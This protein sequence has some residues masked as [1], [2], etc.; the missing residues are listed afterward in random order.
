VGSTFRS[1]R[2]L[3]LI[4]AGLVG[5]AAAGLAVG[6]A[7]GYFQV[8]PRVPAYELRRD[9][10][11][12]GL[13]PG[14]EAVFAFRFR[15]GLPRCWAQVDRPSG[16]ETLSLD[17]KPAAVQ[18][19]APRTPPDEVEGLVAL[20]GPAGQGDTYTLHLV[21]TKL[22]FP[23]GRRPLGAAFTATYWTGPKPAA[24]KPPEPGG[25]GGAPLALLQSPDLQPGQ[26]V[27]LVNAPVGPRGGEGV[28]VRMWLRFYTP[29]ELATAEPQSGGGQ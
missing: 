6:F 3:L 13:L 11:V 7:T 5:L 16:P 21:V 18:G 26:D 23:E 25:P 4:A 22:G 15:G 9:Q 27:E 17:P 24:P 2:I 20:V 8:R 28:R 10:G 14:R 19:P 1:R 29:D 12:E